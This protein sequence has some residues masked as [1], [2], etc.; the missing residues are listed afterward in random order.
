MHF[1][2]A[3][4]AL[5]YMGCGSMA[6]HSHM[7]RASFVSL[8]PIVQFEKLLLLLLLRLLLLLLLLH[9]AVPR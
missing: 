8:A 9:V 4:R 5:P 7:I 2:T 3:L 1:L 6:P